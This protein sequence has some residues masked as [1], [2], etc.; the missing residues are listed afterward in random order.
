MNLLKQMLC[1]STDK[2]SA[3]FHSAVAKKLVILLQKICKIDLSNMDE[4]HPDYFRY[5]PS[6]SAA[7]I[8]YAFA[9]KGKS[10]KAIIR[11]IDSQLSVIF[12]FRLADDYP[13]LPAGVRFV[14]ITVDD[15]LNLQS[16]LFQ[17]KFH[18]GCG[19]NTNPNIFPA[20]IE[21]ETT[22]KGSLLINRELDSQC[23]LKTSITY[24]ISGVNDRSLTLNRDENSSKFNLFFENDASFYTPFLKMMAICSQRPPLFYSVFSEY[25]SY[26]DLTSNGTECFQLLLETYQSEYQNHAISL[27]DKLLLLDMVN[28]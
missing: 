8:F 15:N 19:V 23:N 24:T 21:Y 10:G 26:V 13:T 6:Q 9:Y 7:N 5:T 25:P 16:A 28:V 4:I 11:R 18:F 27:H 17:N 22:S 14:D 2:L 12:S 3:D 1:N 20:T